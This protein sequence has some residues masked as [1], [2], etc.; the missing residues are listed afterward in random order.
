MSDFRE[1]LTEILGEEHV[2]T[3]EPMAAHTTFRGGGAADYLASPTTPDQIAALVRL[4]RQQDVPYM[5]IGNGS[6]LLVSDAG[7]RGVLIRLLENYQQVTVHDRV[8][9]AQAGALLSAI[10][11]KAAKCA[12]TGLEFASGIPGTIGGAMMMNAGAYGG[13]MKD[14]VSQVSVIDPDGRMM[15]YSCA[16]MCFGYRDSVI[17]HEDLTVLEVTLELEVGEEEDI[18]AEMK[19]LTEQRTS[20]QPLEYPSAGS[21]FKR[22]EGYYAGALI[23]EAGL[24]GYRIGGA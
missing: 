13:E 17:A 15:Q 9:Q 1:Q 20:K 7:Y 14:V 24:R 3:D 21:T 12:L 4:C 11:R 2:L 22:P 16:D 10:A 18:Q 23:Q 5:V 8:I 6:N 19:R